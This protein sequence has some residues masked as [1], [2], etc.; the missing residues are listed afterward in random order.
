MQ[1]PVPTGQGDAPSNGERA[2]MKISENVS[3]QFQEFSELVL[4][5]WTLFYLFWLK[6][7]PV[8]Q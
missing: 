7:V 8:V 3:K 5:E 2:A 6:Q 4:N 1:G